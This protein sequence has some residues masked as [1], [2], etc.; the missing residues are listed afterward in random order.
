MCDLGSDCEPQIGDPQNRNKERSYVF[1]V[2]QA[3][4]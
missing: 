1:Q 2:E 3:G 4:S